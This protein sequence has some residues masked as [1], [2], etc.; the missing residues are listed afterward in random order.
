MSGKENKPQRVFQNARAQAVPLSA[1]EIRAAEQVIARDGICVA[2]V[3]R[4]L[5]IGWNRAADLIAHIKGVAAVPK[6]ARH[7]F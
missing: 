3:Q 5:A 7:L 1:D 6:V 4:R 2:T